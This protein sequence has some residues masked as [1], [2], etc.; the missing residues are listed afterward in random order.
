MGD[1]NAQRV[2]DYIRVIVEFILQ[3]EYKDLKCL[4]S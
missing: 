2:P 1:A 4:A 3:P